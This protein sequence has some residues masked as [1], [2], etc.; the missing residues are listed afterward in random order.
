MHDRA[1][2]VRRAV[3][4]GLEGSEDQVL[5]ETPVSATVFTGYTRLYV[6]VSVSAPGCAAGDIVRVRL[7]R[8]DGARVQAA[9]LGRV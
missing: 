5:L 3:L 4:A 9:F 6:P 8:Y 1:E 7:G 2:E